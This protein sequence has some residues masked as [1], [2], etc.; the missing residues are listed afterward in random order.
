MASSA[1]TEQW[2][3]TGGRLSS[4][5]ISVFEMASA[6]STVLPL[7]HSVASDKLAIAEDLERSDNG[8]R[9]I[10]DMLRELASA[11]GV[12]VVGGGTTVASVIL[13]LDETITKQ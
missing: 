4:R 5:T 7:T 11:R 12:W 13:N 10:L 9:P 3:F 2:I 1:S 8:A 6:S